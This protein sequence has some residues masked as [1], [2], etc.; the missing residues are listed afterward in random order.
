M[1]ASALATV[2]AL[3]ACGSQPAVDTASPAGQRPEAVASGLEGLEQQA[4]QLLDGG[5]KAFKARLAELEGHPV[6]VNQWASWCGPCRFEFPFFQRQANQLRG[7]VAFLGVDSQDSREDA[8]AFLK[9]HPV[10]YPHYFD[11]D[12]SVAR[13]FRGGRAFPTTAFYDAS[14]K[15]SYTHIGGYASEAQ[16]QEEIRRYATGG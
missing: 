15:L 5:P 11:P 16:L 12:G 3:G 7:R 9:E 6:V 14:G 8:A 10:P 2:L 4:N 13:V 1:V